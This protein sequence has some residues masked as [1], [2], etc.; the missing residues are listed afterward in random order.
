M[1]SPLP[2]PGSASAYRWHVVGM[3]WWISFF[4]YADR[5]AI[6]SVLPLLEKE[7][8]LTKTELGLLGTSFALVYGLSAPLAGAVVD[9]VSRRN[10]ILVGLYVWSLICMA[11]ALARSFGA[12]L[13]FRAA[14]GLGET[15]YYP[16]ATAMLSDYHGQATRSRALGLHQTSVYAGTIGGGFFAGLIGEEYGWRWSF[17]VF[18][19]LGIVLGVVLARFLREPPRGAA[20]RADGTD[21]APVER[22][23]VAEV[24]RLIWTTPTVLALMLTFLCANFVAMVLLAWM[25]NYL[26]E[27]FKLSLSMAGLTATLFVQTASLAGAALGGWLAD[28]FHARWAGGRVAVQLLGVLG[29]APFV[30]L[31]GQTRSVPVL[32][33]ALSA[34]GLCKGLYDANIFASVFDV[35]RPEARGSTA[36]FMNLVGW[37]GGGAAPLVVGVIAESHGLSLAISSAAGVYLLAGVF[38]LAAGFFLARRDATRWG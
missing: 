2:P 7:M 11:T 24:L 34:W 17:V 33:L 32:V 37:L 1:T 15:C 12:L 6:F 31:C 26:S 9:R 22:L 5:Q 30:L 28:R 8:G 35:V 25:P 18:G 27:G 38:L 3:L 20:D 19:G 4:N 23:P 13:F 29:G 16:A 10:A 14:E 21:W 36:G